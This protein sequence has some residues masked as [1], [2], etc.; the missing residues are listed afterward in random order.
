ML[1]VGMMEASLREGMAVSYE[2]EFPGIH[3]DDEFDPSQKHPVLGF[4]KRLDPREGGCVPTR[5]RS[6]A[7]QDRLQNDRQGAADADRQAGEGHRHEARPTCNNPL[8]H[9]HLRARQDR[10]P[11]GPQ[12]RDLCQSTRAEG[13]S[14]QDG[15]PAD[16]GRAAREPRQSRRPGQL[17][18]G[19]V[20]SL[21][22]PQ[23]HRAGLAGRCAG[24]ASR[25]H[26]GRT[27]TWRHR[28]GLRG[29]GS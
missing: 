17:G 8:W 2:S 26:H 9:R 12:K 24:T 1:A 25:C 7:R 22:Q 5:D 15:P 27:K 3:I 19:V 11:R 23:R 14:L 21:H 28:P 20:Q 4:K 16:D 10:S 13:G 29:A 6:G 18:R